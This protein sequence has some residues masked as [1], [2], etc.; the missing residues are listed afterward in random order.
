M[1]ATFQIEE[2]WGRRLRC[3][4][5]RPSD[6]RDLLR[7]SF[8]AH[9][10]RPCVT[11]GDTR[12]T[13]AL[14]EIRSQRLSAALAARGVVAG[15]RVA[16]M[17]DN[18]IEVVL[19]L[20]AIVE[21]GA[22]IV[23]LGVR[24]RGPEIAFILEDSGASLV[25]V[26]PRLASELP[27]GAARLVAGDGEWQAAL[28]RAD[29]A[30]VISRPIDPESTFGILYTSGTTGR[31]KGAMLA[32]LNIVHSCLHWQHG[33]GL[34]PDDR[35]I[36][37]VP[38]SH[39][40][41]LGGV[42]LPFLHVGGSIAM[43]ADFKARAFLELATSQSITHALMV[44]AMYGLCL[45]DPVLGRFA[46][47]DWR[48]GAYGGAPMPQVTA[49]HFAAA[50][51]ALRMCNCY[52]ATETASPTTIMP[53]G[54]GASRP[55]SIGRVVPCGDVVVVDDHGQPLPAGAEG[56]LW[57]AG[58]MVVPGYWQN[59]AA[60]AAGFAGGYWKSG[61]IGSIDRDGYVRINDRKKDM[62]NRAGFKIYPAEVENCLAAYPDVVESAVV[63]RPD[64]L[65]GET[66]VAFLTVRGEPPQADVVRSWCAERMA[67]YKVPA[68]VFAGH[69]P[70][71]R[72]AN[73]KIQKAVLRDRL[74]TMPLP[75][76]PRRTGTVA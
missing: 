40:T 67:D 73:G 14:V 60:N 63:G 43:L 33:F 69:D 31:P 56:E 37:T 27:A 48:I 61:D 18:S 53:P 22:I 8:A 11:E 3:Y 12:L 28:N 66:V 58:P 74:A 32:H 47:P 34:Y 75:T 35:T 5:D 72:N 52:G 55:D 71:P 45:L 19:A 29:A 7:R 49:E 20:A 26:E 2:H 44:P 9:A 65:L 41:G 23:P 54:E 13:Y 6:V 21:L 15:D 51:P 70:L 30:R 68:L 16:V 24:Q 42:L 59:A 39:V 36:L 1:G 62:I 46:I 17:L 4:A 25:I 57:I 50:F 64:D 38:W 10:D 76:R